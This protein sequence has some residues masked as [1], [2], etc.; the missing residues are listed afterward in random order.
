MKK[1]LMLI[2]I[3]F[4]FLLVGCNRDNQSSEFNP[5]ALLSDYGPSTL[6]IHATYNGTAVTGEPNVSDGSGKIYVYLFK[7]DEL[8]LT[9]R[10]WTYSGSTA[11]AVTAGVEATITIEHI[12][13]GEYY[14]LAFYDYKEGDNS[15]NQTDRY[16]LYAGAG[17]SGFTSVAVPYTV[18]GDSLLDGINFGDTYKLQGQSKFMLPCTVTVNATY[19]GTEYNDGSGRLFVYLYDTLGTDTRTPAPVYAS[20][21]PAASTAATITLTDVVAGSYKAVLF[22]DYS[23]EDGH[24][25]SEGDR[26]VL[27]NNRQ[28]TS[29]ADT[30]TL[31]DGGSATWTQTFGNS[32]TLQEDGAYMT[33]SSPVT[34]TVDA[35]YTGAVSPDASATGKI[36]AYL[37]DALGRAT[38][39]PDNP[40]YTGSTATAGTTGTITITGIVP[41]DYYIVYFYD[42]TYW[43]SNVD[44][45]GDKYVLSGG[46]QYP[47]SATPV[48]LNSNTTVYPSIG[49]DY[50]LT[51]NVMGDAL[52]LQTG[53]LTVTATYTGTEP[54]SNIGSKKIYVYLFDALNTGTRDPLPIYSGSTTG[55]VAVSSPSDITINN[56]LPGSY[57]M[58]VFY[59]FRSG[60]NPDNQTDRYV[61]Y[62]NVEFPASG[63]ST[64]TISTGPNSVTGISFGDGYQLSNGGAYN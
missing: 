16:T 6:T 35:A 24:N 50:A 33:P 38:R 63:A 29:L 19:N 28:Y 49:D 64:V 31:T 45:P 56:I 41:G 10:T 11:A 37:Y 55:A 23:Y 3:G 20:S 32:Y 2:I 59:D 60:T 14:V 47:A 57:Y 17:L 61:I 12:K 4:A 1:L 34:L 13:D 62:N 44:S 7:T 58:V 21:T 54:S 53:S 46:V 26:Y 18:A 48:S 39:L 9:S 8:G 36:Y 52:F 30:I 43:S 42:N 15:D 25:D 27:Y 51:T 22:Y 5:L 40:N